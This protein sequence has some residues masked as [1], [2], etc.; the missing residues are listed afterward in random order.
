MLSLSAIL[1]V[2][3]GLLLRSPA[4][5]AMSNQA[6]DDLFSVPL[7]EMYLMLWHTARAFD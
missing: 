7:I 4:V 6:A 1:E 3:V 2:G 5:V